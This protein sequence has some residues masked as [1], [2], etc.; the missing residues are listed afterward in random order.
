MADA[1]N[2]QDLDQVVVD[3]DSKPPAPSSSTGT[4]LAPSP[5]GGAREPLPSGKAPGPSPS[6][7]KWPGRSSLALNTEESKDE[8]S[9]HEDLE[10]GVGTT[11]K[12][13]MEAVQ[14]ARQLK[15][16]RTIWKWIVRTICIA[17]LAGTIFLGIKPGRIRLRIGGAAPWRW[18][19][20]VS[21]LFGSRAVVTWLMDLVMI[22][23]DRK[24]VVAKRVSFILGGIFDW[25]IFTL[26]FVVV[27]V[28][29]GVLLRDA[30]TGDGNWGTAH[31]LFRRI[32]S[33]LIA[34]SVI[35]TVSKGIARY[36][37]VYFQREA[38]F[39]PIMKALAEE[40]VVVTLLSVCSMDLKQWQSLHGE[41]R[42]SPKSPSPTSRAKA[43]WARAGEKAKNIVK[44][45]VGMKVTVEGLYSAFHQ[46]VAQIKHIKRDAAGKA[47]RAMKLSAFLRLAKDTLPIKTDMITL[48]EGSVQ[49]TDLSLARLH[50]I[51]VHIRRRKLQLNEKFIKNAN[52][53]VVRADVPQII[54]EEIVHRSVARTTAL[55]MVAVM[56]Q[57]QGSRRFVPLDAVFFDLVGMPKA[58]QDKVMEVLDTEGTGVL[59]RDRLVKRFEEIYEKRRDLARSLASTGS[60]LATLERISLSAMYVVLVFVILGIFDQNILEMWFTVSSM[61]LAFVFMFGNSIQ[62][63]FE[64][65]IFIFVTHPFD[66]GDSVLIGGVRQKIRNISIL[67]TEVEKWN[68][69]VVLYPNTV[70]KAS[71]IT[72]ISRMKNFTDEQTWVV[73]IN[74]PQHVFETLSMYWRTYCEDNSEDFTDIVTRIYSATDP[75]KIRITLYFT[76]TFNGLPA[77]RAGNARN[78]LVLHMRKFLVNNGVAYKQQVLPVEIVQQQ[79]VQGALESSPAPPAEQGRDSAT[80]SQRNARDSGAG[81][82]TSFLDLAVAPTAAGELSLQRK[83]SLH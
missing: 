17:A 70:L 21:V 46:S 42:P 6:M 13:E 52:S 22:A 80:F 38:F 73:D 51:G 39:T 11:A 30:A 32:F 45:T 48:K 56:R 27:R 2:M 8:D 10:P 66:V 54:D 28:A 62:Q 77:E 67:T 71:V 64:S 36:M 72:N 3:T 76:Y 47:L 37:E 34:W 19:A 50:K 61:F 79:G 16:L 83:G 24:H 78:K 29:W 81:R 1:R 31:L 4:S 7:L 35:H 68:D 53:A 44:E 25:L 15:Q 12:A 43:S 5:A 40:F 18:T 20:L 69:E 82:S 65:V 41:V 49:P 14:E 33:S 9:D 26:Y 23:L 75:L 58:V 60:V 57:I 63:L 59:T 74:T 55:R